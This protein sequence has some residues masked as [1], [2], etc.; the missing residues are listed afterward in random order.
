MTSLVQHLNSQVRLVRA[1]RSE[2]IRSGV[3]PT[4]TR[5]QAGE[6]HVEWDK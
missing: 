6:G 1:I 3:D 5:P 4:A 2:N